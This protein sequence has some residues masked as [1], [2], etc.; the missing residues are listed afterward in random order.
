MSLVLDMS[1][2]PFYIKGCAYPEGR[3]FPSSRL[4]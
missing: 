3:P 4:M 1:A 2:T